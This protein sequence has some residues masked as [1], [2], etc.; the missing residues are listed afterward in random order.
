[1]APSQKSGSV[2]ITE[3]LISKGIVANQSQ[4]NTALLILIIVLFVISGVIVMVENVG[5]AHKMTPAENQAMYGEHTSNTST[6]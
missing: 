1:M 6:P 2:S 3:F 5:Q 4:A